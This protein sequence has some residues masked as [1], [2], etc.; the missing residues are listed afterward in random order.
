MSS[1]LLNFDA[2]SQEIIS[3][4]SSNR[5]RY[6][7]ITGS[8]TEKLFSLSHASNILSIPAAKPTPAVGFAAGMERIL[9]ACE[10]EKSFSVNEPVIDI[11]LVRLDEGLEI[12]SCEIASKLRRSELIADYDY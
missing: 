11:Y 7:S 5:T 6:I 4:P 2:I 9:L 1:D 3:R 10:S 12:I 8:F